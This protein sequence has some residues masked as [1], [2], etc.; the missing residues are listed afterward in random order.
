MAALVDSRAIVEPLREDAGGGVA[1]PD[2]RGGRETDGM[3]EVLPMLVVVVV[4][5]GHCGGW[6]WRQ[7]PGGHGRQLLALLATQRQEMRGCQ[8]DGTIGSPRNAKLEHRYF[9]QDTRD[10]GA[11]LVQLRQGVTIYNITGISD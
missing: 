9:C 10:H 1:L 7:P 8:W 6:G 3:G 2:E 4:V 5:G 11:E